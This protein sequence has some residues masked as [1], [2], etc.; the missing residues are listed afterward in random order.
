MVKEWS[1]IY[2]NQWDWGFGEGLLIYGNLN[3]RVQHK[4][5]KG[6]LGNQR[7]YVTSSIKVNMYNGIV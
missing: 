4:G 6:D 2:G 5:S 3:L 7:R 1:Y